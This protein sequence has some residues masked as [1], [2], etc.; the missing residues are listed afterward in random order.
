MTLF[1]K[2]IVLLFRIEEVI[3]LF[4]LSCLTNAFYIAGGTNAFPPYLTHTPEV[5]KPS[6]LACWLF[7]KFVLENLF[8]VDEVILVTSFWQNSAKLDGFVTSGV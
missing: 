5:T 2:F 1:C 3:I 4:Y 6:N 8:E 7:T